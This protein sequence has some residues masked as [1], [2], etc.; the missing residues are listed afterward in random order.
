MADTTVPE[1]DSQILQEAL[2]LA[3]ASFR[4]PNPE[5]RKVLEVQALDLWRQAHQ[6]QRN[7]MY[8]RGRS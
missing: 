8:A 4:E 3:D 7:W 6:A 2:A 1:P 5:V